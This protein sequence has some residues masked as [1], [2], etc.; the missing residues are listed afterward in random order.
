[1]LKGKF[2]L[3]KFRAIFLSRI[4][5]ECSAGFPGF[6]MTL[7]DSGTKEL[8]VHG[9]PGLSHFVASTR[10]YLQ[11][12]NLKGH[13]KETNTATDNP[14]Y[15]DENLTVIAIPVTVD[16][17]S[18]SVPSSPASLKRKR[19]DSPEGTPASKRSSIDNRAEA[20][21]PSP[22]LEIK[23]LRN[24]P[25]AWRD[26]VISRILPGSQG[27]SLYREKQA[28]IQEIKK[29]LPTWTHRRV[30][31]SY[32]IIG[33]EFRGKFNVKLAEAL[34]VPPGPNRAKLTRGESVTL[35]DGRVITPDMVIGESSRAAS[36]L[37]V[38][39]PGTDYIEPFIQS[40]QIQN[41]RSNGQNQLHCV[42]HMAP[43]EVLQ[44]TRYADWIK[45]LGPEVHHIISNHDICS[46]AVNF[47]GSAAMQDRLSEL[48]KE[49][50]RVPY[51]D[52]VDG[53][54]LLS[55]LD[56][57]PNVHIARNQVI[58]MRPLTSPV[59]P[60]EEGLDLAEAIASLPK[61][62]DKTLFEGVREKILA[63]IPS[64][65]PCPGD[66][67]TL[68]FLGTGSA[69]PGKY[70]NVS[71]ALVT[72]PGHGNVLLDCGEGTLGQLRRHFGTDVNDV[73]RNI[74]CIF[75]SHIHADHH[76]GICQL[77]LE[78]R[79]LSSPKI[80]DLFVI[81]TWTTMVYIQEYSEIEDIGLDAVRFL[82]APEI[83][84][85]KISNTATLDTVLTINELR[86][87]LGLGSVQTAAVIHR[88][89]AF[90]LV[91]RHK[92]GWSLTYS[93]DTT[94]CQNLADA[95]KGSTL[96]IHEATMSDEQEEMA[97]QKGH[98][99]VGQ[100]CEIAKRMEAKKLILTHF[101]SRY[102]K[103]PVLGNNARDGKTRSDAVTSPE[104]FVAFDFLHIRLG[105]MAR[106][107]RYIPNLEVAFSEIQDDE[108]LPSHDD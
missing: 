21:R 89:P 102:P 90:G 1:M 7:A 39:C 34:G 75:I 27:T 73:L 83:E 104:V 20:R 3:S 67:V 78:R 49:L 77:L 53:A 84:Y 103:L 36:L 14:V 64:T 46:N 54:L 18:L 61:A 108:E 10:F 57:G 79:K 100:A 55:K 92:D 11:R 66:D 105:D 76:M 23:A 60:Y 40:K 63:E 82:L 71:G 9:P 91:L 44:D 19:S 13:I 72:I 26:F 42:F 33:P 62:T 50:F 65:I 87:T 97:E 86:A 41:I 6:T 17:S 96:L 28:T 32:L 15:K 58:G 59:A 52:K 29:R 95:G 47:V 37:V 74:K 24:D 8:E 93:G 51:S 31:N 43:L 94:P 98:S 99:T 16:G 80:P 4:A 30:V 107:E 56:L 70:R 85:R 69:V 88:T 12:D 2:G 81:C 22:N 106:A 38:D 45:S 5:T 48:D 68:T 35:S 25:A 101:S